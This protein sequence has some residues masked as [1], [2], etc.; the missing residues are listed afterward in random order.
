MTE[1]RS[2]ALALDYVI[3]LGIALVLTMGLLVASG[4]FIGDQRESAARTQLEVVGQQVAADIEAADRLAVAAGS[5]GTVRIDRQLPETI[6]GS[7]YRLELVEEADPYLW[8]RTVRPNTTARVEFTNMT[9]VSASDVGGGSIVINHTA[10]ALVL[11]SGG[12]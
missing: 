5:S 4:G 11:E 7:Q 6:A 10:D 3:G 1:E 9:A 8:L 12:T 2:Q